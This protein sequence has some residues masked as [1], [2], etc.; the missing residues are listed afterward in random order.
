MVGLAVAHLF[1]RSLLDGEPPGPGEQRRLVD[2]LLLPL[3][4]GTTLTGTTGATDTTEGAR[5]D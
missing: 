3:L 2:E 5:H 4:T 1:L